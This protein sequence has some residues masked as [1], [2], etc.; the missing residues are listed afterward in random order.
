MSKLYD[1]LSYLERKSLSEND[2]L[3]GISKNEMVLLRGKRNNVI[4]GKN[5]V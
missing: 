5:W 3:D 4:V 1:S 2:I